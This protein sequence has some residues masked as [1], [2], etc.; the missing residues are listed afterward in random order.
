M[1]MDRSTEHRCRGWGT[2][3]QRRATSVVAMPPHAAPTSAAVGMPS[4]GKVGRDAT[5]KGTEKGT[6]S[7]DMPDIFVDDYL[8]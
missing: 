5:S 3:A 7:G 8:I 4:P 2:K 1:L 6:A